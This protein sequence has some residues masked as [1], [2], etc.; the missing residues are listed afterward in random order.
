M[1]AQHLHQANTT[2]IYTLSLS[3]QPITRVITLGITNDFMALPIS[4]LSRRQNFGLTGSPATL[5]KDYNDA[6]TLLEQFL[7]KVGQIVNLSYSYSVYGNSQPPSP[8]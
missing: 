6:N 7:T 5:E 1:M 3:I 8:Q 2:N 4:E